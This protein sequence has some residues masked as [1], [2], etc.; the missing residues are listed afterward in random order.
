MSDRR[1]TLGPDVWEEL[2]E[3]SWGRAPRVLRQPLAAPLLS[4]E[5][6]FEAVQRACAAWGA[7]DRRATVNFSADDFL[8]SGSDPANYLPLERDATADEYRARIE[9]QL[10][11]RKF[12]VVI[13]SLQAHDER[14]WVRMRE[15]LRPLSERIPAYST[16]VCLFLGNYDRTP[17]GVHRDPG[18]IF[19]FVAGGRKRMRVWPAESF[20]DRDGPVRRVPGAGPDEGTVLEGGPGDVL[21]WPSSHW[22]VG[23]GLDSFSI[24]L[25]LGVTPVRPSVDAWTMLMRR[26]E[27]MVAETINGDWAQCGL[28]GL[29]G[30]ADALPKIARLAESALRKAAADPELL[31]DLR[32]SWLNHATGLGCHLIPPPL[33]ARDL[34]DDETVRGDAGFPIAWMPLPDHE[35]L[36]SAGGHSVTVPADPRIQALIQCLNGGR[37]ATIGSLVQEFAGVSELDGVRFVA[38][39]DGIRTLLARLVSFRALRAVRAPG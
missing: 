13:N 3:N 29:H 14:L 2:L 11:G 35:M 22:H 7:G 1:Y 6:A 5:E 23:E 28:A 33:P 34:A 38:S 10:N 9:R 20:T 12:A 17:Y 8:F 18:S 27:E 26:V 31:Q 21:F 32:K 25:S 37:S 24:A 16:N 19:Q 4:G 15:F 30:S 36:C 39:P